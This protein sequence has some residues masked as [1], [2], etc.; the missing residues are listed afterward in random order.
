V[1]LERMS[2][3]AKNMI[4]FADLNCNP[5]DGT[6]ATDFSSTVHGP[7]PN[8]TTHLLFNNAENLDAVMKI[9]TQGFVPSAG[10]TSGIRLLTVALRPVS[11]QGL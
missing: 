4:S 11:W 3:Q 8:R 7:D 10:N 2:P 1:V 9:T 6:L 5:L